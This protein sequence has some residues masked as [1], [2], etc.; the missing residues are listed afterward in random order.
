[1]IV[2][3]NSVPNF[4]FENSNINN[5]ISKAKPIQYK[6]KLTF[7]PKIISYSEFIRMNPK[8]TKTE[9]REAIKTFYTNLL[10]NN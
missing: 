8:A 2:K 3:S 6:F 10:D 5:P 9:R 7:L 4:L 1:M